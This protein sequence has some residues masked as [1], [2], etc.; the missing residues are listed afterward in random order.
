M[1]GEKLKW[2]ALQDAGWQ[3]LTDHIL[4]VLNAKQKNVV[5]I[6]WGGC[7]CSSL[8]VALLKRLRVSFAHK[9]ASLIDAS[10]NLVLKDAH[11]SPLGGAAFNETK[12]FRDA[13]DYL[14]K[15]GR[16]VVN[17]KIEN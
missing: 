4:K 17:W 5:Y 2:R 15:H 13:N 16:P 11:P 14:T 10:D 9:K 12:C 6:L 8:C 7:G 3:T 1:E